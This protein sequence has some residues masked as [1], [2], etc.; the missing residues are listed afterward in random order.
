MTLRLADK[1]IWDFWFAQD[2]GKTHIFYLQASR[3]LPDAEDRHWNVTIGHAVSTDLVNW[4]ILPDALAPTPHD[5]AKPAWDDYTTWTG[6]IIRHDGLWY[7]FYT[8][9]SRADDGLVQRIGYATSDDLI[10]WE[11]SAEN[12]VMEADPQHYELLQNTVWHD[13]AWRDPYVFRD[14]A[15]TFHAL[16]TA[17]ANHGTSDERGVIG[18]ATSPDL[19]RWTVQPPL[20]PPGLG[21]GHMEVPQVIEIA[22]RCYLIFSCPYEYLS[23]TRRE[24]YKHN[25][26]GGTFY[27]IG[28]GL[29]GPWHAPADDGLIVSRGEQLYSG[30][31]LKHNE[32]WYAFAFRGY[33][34]AGV[35]QGEIT[36]PMPVH[37]NEGGALQVSD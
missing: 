22:G 21:F 28:D 6:S 23:D 36:D 26:L 16:I 18:H 4:E 31:L 15:G 13:Q 30:K 33:D 34:E 2:A 3:E 20:T 10:T 27:L 29:T 7:M 8:G 14:D 5:P 11:K 12:P 1:W 37:V 17:R 19:K 24:E 35:F 32:N 9:S 25:P